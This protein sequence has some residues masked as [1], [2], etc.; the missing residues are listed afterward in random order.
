MA[1]TVTSAAAV[2][3]NIS[4]IAGMLS[5]VVG[6]LDKTVGAFE[7]AWTCRSRIQVFKLR[8]KVCQTKLQGWDTIWGGIEKESLFGSV[9]ADEVANLLQ[10]VEAAHQDVVVAIYSQDWFE[11]GQHSSGRWQSIILDQGMARSRA[12][13]ASDLDLEPGF[14]SRVAMAL[15]KNTS[16]E[17]KLKNLEHR[18]DALVHLSRDA[19]DKHQLRNDEKELSQRF[20]VEGALGHKQKR[21]ARI[22]RLWQVFNQAHDTLDLNERWALL[23]KPLKVDEQSFLAKHSNVPVD[24]VQSTEAQPVNNTSAT[25]FH[26][27]YNLDIDQ[28][29]FALTTDLETTI[30]LSNTLQKDLHFAAGLYDDTD[31][32]KSFETLVAVQWASISYQLATWTTILCNCTWMSHLCTCGVRSALVGGAERVATFSRLHHSAIS[33]P[34]QRAAAAPKISLG[35]ALAEIILVHPLSDDDIIDGGR[36]LIGCRGLHR[37]TSAH[38]S[39]EKL[40]DRVKAKNHS[41]WLAVRYC[42]AEDRDTTMSRS[43]SAQK[44]DAF[45]SNVVRPLRRYAKGVE[46]NYQAHRDDVYR[47]L[48]LLEPHRD[49][50]T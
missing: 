28:D 33:T 14:L 11:D 9:G 24:Y 47:D 19:Y 5:L 42:F 1:S 31:L 7:T 2:T 16:L 12:N 34:C 50:S 38:P 8:L 44:V 46:L 32:R 6:T 17:T 18:I 43:T 48:E 13:R 29:D 41:Y 49:Y 20:D 3:G 21:N 23:L 26:A 10:G 27:N 39:Y 4:F 25:C 37:A 40:L 36:S 45:V 30:S 22:E 15:W 35:I